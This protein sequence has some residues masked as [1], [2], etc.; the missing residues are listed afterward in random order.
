[1]DQ[2]MS[3]IHKIENSGILQ[4]SMYTSTDVCNITASQIPCIQHGLLRNANILLYTQS[5]TTEHNMDCSGISITFYTHT[6]IDSS[7]PHGLLN[8]QPVHNMDCSG[9]S[10]AFYAHTSIG[11]YTQHA[12]GSCTQHGLIRN[13]DNIPCTHFW[14][15]AVNNV[16]V[17][18]IPCTQHGLL[19]SVNNIPC[20]QIWHSCI[21]DECLQLCL[22]HSLYTTWTAQEC[23]QH[24][25]H[26][27]LIDSCKQ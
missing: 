7:I 15:T 22:Q 8:W 11:S 17:C 23:Q 27:L 6:M 24:F 2:I 14:L 9:M 5:L 4:K 18:T 3:H 10:T 12:I 1:M 20:A 19:R 26:P 13:V 25:K 21:L 16:S